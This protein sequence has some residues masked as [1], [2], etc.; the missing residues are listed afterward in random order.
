MVAI[1]MDRAS[2][3]RRRTRTEEA[4]DT[5]AMDA[6]AAAAKDTTATGE[7]WRWT[8]EREVAKTTAVAAEAAT[9]DPQPAAQGT[10]KGQLVS[11][12]R[13]ATRR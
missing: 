7:A 1:W 2:S 8:H 12:G 5:T 3:R 10:G 4:V 11:G 13:G 6:K 9:Q